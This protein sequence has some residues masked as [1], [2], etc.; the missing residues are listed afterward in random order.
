MD[1]GN[2]YALMTMVGS[3]VLIPLAVALEGPR[4][5]GVWSSALSAG[6]TTPSLV[7]NCLLGGLFFY[8]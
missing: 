6:Q 7:K 5:A 2:L 3:V 1:A 8:L 4:V